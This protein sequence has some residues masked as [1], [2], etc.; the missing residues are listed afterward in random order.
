MKTTTPKRY[1]K[2]REKSATELFAARVRRANR[3]DQS[4]LPTVAQLIYLVR[5]YRHRPGDAP[6]MP[7]NC[8][9]GS[10]GRWQCAPASQSECRCDDSCPRCGPF[11]GFHTQRLCPESARSGVHRPRDPAELCNPRGWPCRVCRRCLEGLGAHLRA[12]ADT[13]RGTKAW[14][15]M[16]DPRER[17]RA[18]AFARVP[19]ADVIR[20][21]LPYGS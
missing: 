6:V 2:R 14:A 4:P 3:L 5:L 1:V 13:R 7:E 16:T 15:K 8:C 19:T 12:I 21:R 9:I 18:E 17:Q 10:D 20:R 11:T